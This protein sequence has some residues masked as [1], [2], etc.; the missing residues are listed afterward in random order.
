VGRTMAK[1]KVDVTEVLEWECPYCCM[2][3][4]SPAWA[5]RGDNLLCPN[6]TRQSVMAEQFCDCRPIKFEGK[7]AVVPAS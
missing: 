1:L 3:N 6:C 7:K 4:H 2:A 5:R